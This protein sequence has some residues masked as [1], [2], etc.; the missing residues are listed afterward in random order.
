MRK[1]LGL[2]LSAALFV[3]LPT[4]VSAQTATPPPAAAAPT[5]PLGTCEGLARDWKAVEYELAD[6]HAEGVT[7]DSAPRA[8]MRAVRDQNALL[9]AQIAVSLMRHHKCALPKRAPSSLTYML[10]AIKCRTKKLEG[11]YKATECDYST[12]TPLGQ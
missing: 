8:T 4:Q 2:T 9:K 3:Q 12:W 10:D 5:K 11:N 6:N 7:D 1:G